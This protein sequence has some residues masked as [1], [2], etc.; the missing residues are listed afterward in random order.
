MN[1]ADV[2]DVSRQAVVV[3]LKIGAPVL[4][5]ALLVG[6][7]I[8]LFGKTHIFR[9]RGRVVAGKHM[10]PRRRE[11]GRGKAWRQYGNDGEQYPQL[12]ARSSHVKSPCPKSAP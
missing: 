7:A 4:L 5:L 10:R 11:I 1:P 2:L 3:M 12:H 9:R 6:L 8:A